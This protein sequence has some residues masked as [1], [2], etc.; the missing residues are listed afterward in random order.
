M[1]LFS[2][3]NDHEFH[4]LCGYYFGGRLLLFFAYYLDR[5]STK[6]A[7]V[8]NIN[9]YILF[10]YKQIIRLEQYLEDIHTKYFFYSFRLT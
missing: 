5:S 6:T 4:Y 3:R 2:I 8:T 10:K 1:A 9:S 7:L